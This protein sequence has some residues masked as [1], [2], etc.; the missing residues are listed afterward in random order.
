[1][2]KKIKKT[3]KELKIEMLS[4][5]FRDKMLKIVESFQEKER[6]E[7]DFNYIFNIRKC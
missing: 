3:K 5:K 7:M 1:M 2:P 6:C 4:H